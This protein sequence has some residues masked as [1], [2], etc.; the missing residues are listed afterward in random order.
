MRIRDS[1]TITWMGNGDARRRETKLAARIPASN[2]VRFAMVVG[3]IGLLVTASIS[4]TALVLD[5]HNEQRLVEVQTRQAAAVISSTILDISDPL[6]TALQIAEATG[7]DPQKFGQSMS[8]YV[9]TDGLFVS[10]SL[11]RGDGPSLR[12]IAS[13]GSSPELPPASTTA[14]AFIARAQHSPTFVVTDI[15]V[16]GLQRIGYAI[17]DPKNPTYAVYAERAI[18]ANREVPA[19]KNSAFAD[20]NYATYLGS[21][22]EASDLATTDLPPSQLPLRGDTATEVIPFGDTT[23]IL[24][25]AGRGHLGGALGAD[26]PWILLGGGAVLTFAAGLATEQLVRRRREAEQNARTISGL[27]EELDGLY[28]EQRS[29]A[30]TLQRAL[31]PQTNPDIPSLEIASRYV[32]GAVGVDIGGD[33]YSSIAIDERHFAFVVGDVSGRGIGAATVMARLRFTI[34]A[35]LLEGHPP[36]VVLE[37]CSRQFDIGS[38]GHFATVLIG[39]GDLVSREITLANAG[40]LNPLFVSETQSEYVTTDVG[41]PLGCGPCAYEA[42][43]TYLSPGWAVLAFTDGLI[44]RRGES[45]D[46]GFE[47]LA[48][49]AMGPHR[50]LDDL[51]SDLV[52]QMNHGGGEDDIAVLAFR[53]SD[54]GEPSVAP[55]ISIG[56]QISADGSDAERR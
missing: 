1:L 11:W 2:P 30:E 4:W 9:G 12:A 27:Y 18:P 37:M 54:L 41:L 47:R 36:D 38:D 52:S 23:L 13:I 21:T 8:P 42:T 46:I 44:E 53:W 39:V 3:L 35:Y 15:R 10:A 17:G 31:L 43:S 16:D 34:R 7:G 48:R 33:W 14:H 19:E 26:L 51:V 28:G 50:T 45:I 22:T 25:A 56:V 49:L 24:V 29:I 20:L 55:S 6:S 5:R 40:H 32:A